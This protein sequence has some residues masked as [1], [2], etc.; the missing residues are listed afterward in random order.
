[1]SNIFNT[2]A[3][4]VISIRRLGSRDLGVLYIMFVLWFLRIAKLRGYHRE[5]VSRMNRIHES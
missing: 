3:V 2:D 5:E 1:M 4:F